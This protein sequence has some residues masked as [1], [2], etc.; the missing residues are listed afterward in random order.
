MYGLVSFGLVIYG[1]RVE[2]A[3]VASKF[4]AEFFVDDQVKPVL[5]VR[6][7][8]DSSGLSLALS[9]CSSRG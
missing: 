5:I 8:F 7:H 3:S 4:F 9:G 1:F 6:F 2:V